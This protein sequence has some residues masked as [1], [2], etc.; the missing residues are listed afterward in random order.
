MATGL[1]ALIGYLY[2]KKET[3]RLEEIIEMCIDV[4]NAEK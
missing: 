4:I 2:I 3:G 1:E